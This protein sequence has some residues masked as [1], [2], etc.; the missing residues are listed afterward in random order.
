MQI[1]ISNSI[2][3]FRG[4]I[5]NTQKIVNLFN[6]RVFADGGTFEAES[7]LKN[8]IIELGGMSNEGLIVFNFQQRV[9]TDG[10]VCEAQD[11][12]INTLKNLNN[13]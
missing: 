13:I 2:R 12:L 3:G 4:G 8:T 10:G 7:C 11:C 5:G 9:L 1:S 6:T